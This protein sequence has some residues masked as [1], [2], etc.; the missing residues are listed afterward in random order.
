MG[1]GRNIGNKKKG[2]PTG[3]DY[4][5]TRPPLFKKGSKVCKI[6]CKKEEKEKGGCRGGDCSN[7]VALGGM[8]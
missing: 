4:Q 1:V 5:I 6:F 2:G 7:S 8:R 3:S